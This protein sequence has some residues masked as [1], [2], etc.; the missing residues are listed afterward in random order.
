MPKDNGESRPIGLPTTEDKVLGRAIVRLL[1]PSYEEAFYDFSYGFRPGRSA[2]QALAAFWQ[3]ARQGGVRWVLEVDS[4]KYFDSVCRQRRFELI[5]QRIG[6]GVVLRLISKWLHAALTHD[7]VSTSFSARRRT[8]RGTNGASIHPGSGYGGQTQRTDWSPLGEERRNSPTLD[9]PHLC[10]GRVRAEAAVGRAVAAEP[11]AHSK[12]SWQGAVAICCS[13]SLVSQ[14]L[15]MVS[16][17]KSIRPRT[18]KSR[19]YWARS[20]E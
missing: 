12:R 6:D 14:G 4:R 11:A 19:T 17:R 13:C 16:R 3:Q 9:S 10:S 18:P 7:P 5:R 8:R 20:A 15:A 2:Q 1:E